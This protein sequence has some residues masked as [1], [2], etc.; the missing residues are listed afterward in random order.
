MKTIIITGINGMDGSLLAEKLLNDGHK[1]IGLIRRS[2][3]EDKKLYNIKN[4]LNHPNLIL[5][6]FDL[7]DSSS[8]WRLVGK[9]KPDQ[10]Y[11]LA[12]QSH[13]GV[14][15]RSP[16][17]TFQMNISGT[18]A[19]LEAIRAL[20]PTTRFY[21]AS[22]SEMFGDSPIIPQ[23]E[24]TQFNPMSPYAVSK[25]AA[26][27]MVVNYRKGYG[28][29]LC[30]GILFNHE[31]E[32][33]GEQFVTRKITKSVAKILFKKQDKLILGNLEARRDWGYAKEYV[34]GMEMML[35]H[36]TPDDYVLATNETHTIQEFVE[37]TF[38]LAQLDWKD[39]VVID[40][41]FKRPSEVPVLCGDYSKAE[42]VLGWKPQ[43]KFKELVSIMYN[44]DVQ[45][46]YK[47]L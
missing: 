6:F 28:L 44:Y 23:N 2:S 39:Y 22:S 31:G 41:K 42:R 16:E 25:C 19:F 27:N 40:D 33:R 36:H 15:F 11:S 7:T 14:C 34:V 29:F 26:H 37:E 10:I 9:Y 12:A 30:N 3:M 47:S 35:N 38:K 21:N 24:N 18:V 1:V 20:S 13:V 17:G 8:I 5:E 43:V 46:E 4:V 32:R 45:E